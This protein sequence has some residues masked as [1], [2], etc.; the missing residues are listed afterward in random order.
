MLSGVCF[1]FRN[2]FQQYLPFKVCIDCNATPRHIKRRLSALDAHPSLL[3]RI[4]E[5]EIEMIEPQFAKSQVLNFRTTS[6]ISAFLRNTPRMPRLHTARFSAVRVEQEHLALLFHSSSL[7][8]LILVQCRLRKMAY[9]PPSRIRHL[10]VRLM[11]NW[12]HVEALLAHCGANLETLELFSRVGQLPMS[13]KLPHLPKLRKLQCMGKSG[14]TSY[15][16]TLN[17]LAPQLEDLEVWGREPGSALVALP[18]GLNRVRI[19][20]WLIENCNFGAHAFVR[21]QHL[22]IRYYNH[23]LVIPT[24]QRI[25]PNLTSL[26]L[27]IHFYSRSLALLLARALPKVTRLQLNMSGAPRHNYD[28]SRNTTETR[29]GPLSSIYVNVAFL[30]VLKDRM[31]LY[32]EWVTQTILRPTTGLGG[33]HL[34]EVEVVFSLFGTSTPVSWWYW[35]RVKEEWCFKQY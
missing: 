35:K 16:D 3:A 2:I 15:L 17:S 33:P 8:A 10:T 24:I 1:T 7:H 23:G 29:E 28:A 4:S 22:H 5:I 25:F 30:R 6:Y 31:E 21:P 34:Q 26:E 19:D 18:V 11:D 20:Q 13:A 9:L 12:L 14:S 27:D 32:K